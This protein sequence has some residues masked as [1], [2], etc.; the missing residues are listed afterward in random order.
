MIT[1][2]DRASSAPRVSVLIP[3]FGRPDDLRRTL[4]ETRRQTFPDR[5]T[6]VIDDGTP[7]P[8]IA[9]AARAFPECRYVRLE[10]NQGLIGA[11]NSGAGHCRGEYIV[12]L[13][14]DS[15]L[16]ASDAI[17]RIVAFM[18]ANPAVAVAALNVRQPRSGLNW[19][20]TCPPFAAGTYVGCGNVQRRSV[21]EQVGGYIAEFVRQGEEIE[22]ALRVIDAGYSIMALPEIEV[23]HN[24]SPVHRNVLRI[25]TF[26]A[27]NTLRREVL[28]API[29]LMPLGIG[30][31]LRFLLVNR[32]DIDWRLLFNELTRGPHALPAMARKYRRPISAPAY[33]RCL[34]LRRSAARV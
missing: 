5:E 18:D 29:V 14:D 10:R 3:C 32:K 11:R 12:N 9:E 25:R 34:Q 26:D 1:P 8:S 31:F 20:G 19:P 16:A 15:W 28:R 23:V 24:E 21:I 13:D 2:Q 4:E 6:V 7:N 33:L 30:L 22:H 27:L 17:E